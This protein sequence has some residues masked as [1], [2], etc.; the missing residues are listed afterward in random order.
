M[1]TIEVP[2]RATSPDR[3]EAEFP[4]SEQGSYLVQVAEGTP[5]GGLRMA[6]GGLVVPYSPEFRDLEADKGL[7]ERLA[8]IT[9]GKVILNPPESFE[10]GLPPAYGDMPLAW[11]LLVAAALLLP[12]DIAYRRLNLRPTEALAVLAAA[13]EALMRRGRGRQEGPA[14][15]VLGVI[16][17]RRV[18]RIKVRGGDDAPDF[19]RE[20]TPDSRDIH[21][22]SDKKRG[23]ADEAPTQNRDQVE[24]LE[25]STERWLRAKR[26]AKRK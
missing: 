4:A 13:R 12:L 6:T 1:D 11:W 2:L 7:L 16:R 5:E 17:S 21:N 10:P 9:G 24:T 22:K 23:V 18:H 20:T 8:A 19:S 14:S 25:P 26:R 3:W 15:P